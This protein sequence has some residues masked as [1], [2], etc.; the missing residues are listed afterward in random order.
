MSLLVAYARERL[1]PGR[2]LP[3][4]CLVVLAALAGRGWTGIQA[5][6]T[7]AAGAFGLVIAFRI[8]DDLMDRDRDRVRH[9][10]RVV[11]R[12]SSSSTA[13]LP[14]AAMVLAIAAAILVGLAHGPASVAVLAA[15]TAMLAASYATRGARSLVH[16]WILLLKYGVFASALMGIPAALTARGLASAAAGFAA[17]CV[18]EWIDDAESPVFSFGGSR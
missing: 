8:W 14:A 13:P 5:A 4:G 15:Y 9:P 3:A 16:E 10:E 1:T 12:A 7:D 17:A 18:Y 2:L 6:A 11:V